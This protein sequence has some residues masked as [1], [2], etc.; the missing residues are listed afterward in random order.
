MKLFSSNNSLCLQSTI[1]NYFNRT[2]G[3]QGIVNGDC[4]TAVEINHEKNFAFVEVCGL[5]E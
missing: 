1:A 5:F 3:R 4:V 2:L